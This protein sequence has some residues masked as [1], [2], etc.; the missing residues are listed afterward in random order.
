MA[1]LFA[2]LYASKIKTINITEGG[3]DYS[4]AST[5]D[6]AAGNRYQETIY[7]FPYTNPCIAIH[8]FIHYGV[9]ENYPAGKVKQFD[10]QAILDQFD[11]IRRSLI[12]NQ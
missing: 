9:F 5:T 7:A 3:N 12:V 1:Q 10:M 11:Q 8:Y 4:V 6:A 2:F